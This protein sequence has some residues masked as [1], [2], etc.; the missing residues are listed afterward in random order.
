MKKEAAATNTTSTT[1]SARKRSRSSSPAMKK[2][3]SVIALPNVPFHSHN[4]LPSIDTMKQSFEQQIEKELEIHLDSINS[5]KEKLLNFTNE[6]KLVKQRINNEKATTNGGVEAPAVTEPA[7]SKRKEKNKKKK[8]KKLLLA[9]AAFQQQENASAVA[10]S[11]PARDSGSLKQ[12]KIEQDLL[13]K[14]LIEQQKLQQ[15]QIEQLQRQIDEFVQAETKAANARQKIRALGEAAACVGPVTMNVASVGGAGGKGGGEASGDDLSL[16]LNDLSEALI[17]NNNLKQIKGRLGG[18][19]KFSFT[20][21]ELLKKISSF[22]LIGGFGQLLRFM[23]NDDI[24][25]T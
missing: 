10:A 23:I 8:K 11:G 12:L 13:E 7:E 6:A 24:M 20:K 4:L 17:K 19:M 15:M 9:A 18:F 21:G 3:P 14:Q 22:D 2:P 1:T 16:V 5:F 25:G